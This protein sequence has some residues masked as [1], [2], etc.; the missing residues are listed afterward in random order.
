MYVTQDGFISGPSGELDWFPESEDTS[1]D[2]IKM[3]ENAD[4]IL[5]GREIYKV[6][7]DYWPTALSNP[8]IYPPDIPLAQRL[9][10][11]P[12]YVF[13]SK[14]DGVHWKNTSIVK[15]RAEEAVAQLKCQKAG[16]LIVYGGAVLARLLMKAG[17]LDEDQ[18]SVAPLIVG[19]GKSLYKD[20]GYLSK[21]KLVTTKV[22][23]PAFV[24]FYYQ[25]MS[26]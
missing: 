16:D 23:E 9:D 18:L 10:A 6:F 22:M 7:E 13:S 8:D 17:L 20:L 1:K 11:F 15:N 21:L 2:S 26:K 4:G 14:L 19:R 3:L 24:K 5:S 25:P 12:K